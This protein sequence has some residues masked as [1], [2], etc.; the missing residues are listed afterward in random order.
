MVPPR[1]ATA[2]AV[3][4]AR[5]PVPRVPPDRGTGPRPGVCPASLAGRCAG[6]GGRSP[7]TPRLLAAVPAGTVPARGDDPPKPPVARCGAPR[8]TGRSPGRRPG[9]AG[10]VRSSGPIPGPW[11]V[12][13]TGRPVAR[14]RP[15]VP[16]RPLGTGRP[17]PPART[18]VPAPAPLFPRAPERPSGP[19][20][21]SAPER[22]RDPGRPSFPAVAL[23]GR[24]PA[25]S[26]RRGRPLRA[27]RASG[28]SS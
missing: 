25:F 14:G 22:P 8:Y 11:R 19:V 3:R 24:A 16:A 7:G 5:A 26:S 23:F 27:G 18:P 17:P 10:P 9:L 21:L 28:T 13:V 20:P 2:S 6:L 4:P 12:P 15:P 1:R